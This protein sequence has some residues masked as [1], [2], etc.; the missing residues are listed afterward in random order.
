MA[1][2]LV[3]GSLFGAVWVVPGGAWAAWPAAVLLLATVDRSRP[4]AAFRAGWWF[5]F[6]AIAAGFH[7]TPLV[8]TRFSQV[9]WIGA[10][11]LFVLFCVWGGLQFGV[12]AWLTAWLRTA[13]GTPVLCYPIVWVALERVWPSILPWQL[14][15]TQAAWLGLVQMVEWTGTAGVSFMVMWG[16][17][18]TYRLA[19]TSW[20]GRTAER[21][22][23]RPMRQAP[24]PRRAY[25]GLP[26]PFLSCRD[27]ARPPV[28]HLGGYLLVLLLVLAWGS[29]RVGQ[30]RRHL[31]EQ[32]ELRVALVQPNVDVDRRLEQCAQ[33]TQEVSRPVDLVCW[34]ES[35]VEAVPLHWDR[36]D[37]IRSHAPAGTGAGLHG[38]A[39]A[40]L[41][42]GGSSFAEQAAGTETYLITAFLL[43]GGDRV[44]GRYHK[45]RLVPFGEYVPGERRLGWLARFNR[46]DERNLPGHSAEPLVIPD[47]ARLGILI[48][49]EDLFA[50]LSRDLVRHGA[51][52]L[53]NL[54]NDAWFAGTTAMRQHQE[55]ARLRSI[56]TRRYLLRCTT[57]GS[58][59]VIAPTGEVL[60]Q[61]PLSQP[62]TLIATV[63]CNRMRT[64]Y[65][66]WGDILGWACVLTTG[67]LSALGWRW[68]R[69]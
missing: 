6:A 53:V 42:C 56:E 36:F 48:C 57:T 61:A 44:R 34:P 21:G 52:L 16:V 37:G 38:A 60:A 50:G 30:I 64:P 15:Q 58:T 65:A 35:T 43:D 39:T 17:A 47:K 19:R 2:T 7:W 25:T 33:L 12:F 46:A 11:P 8:I 32:P 1:A 9:P 54:T 63:H 10:I 26:P 51:D 27:R 62:T 13:T 31:A 40:F 68:S 41:L 23:G 67:A 18:L 20:R 28:W 24:G 29:R 66:R 59:A 22:G 69:A 3:G 14:G 49:Y 45:R 55:L 4:A 5:G